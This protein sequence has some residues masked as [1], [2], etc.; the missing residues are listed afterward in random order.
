MDIIDI[1]D[2]VAF[3]RKRYDSKLDNS[4]LGDYVIILLTQ[5]S[6]YMNKFIPCLE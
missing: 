2:V 5:R 6:F 1:L 3:D 4:G